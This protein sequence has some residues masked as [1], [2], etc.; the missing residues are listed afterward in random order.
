MLCGR[1]IHPVIAQNAGQPV[2]RY[3]AAHVV[4]MVDNDIGGEPAQ[5]ERQ[6][7]MRAAMQRRLC[8]V[9]QAP[10]ARAAHLFRGIGTPGFAANP[11]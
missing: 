10:W 4:H 5:H 1:V 11:T 2:V 6:V 8:M 7:I 3:A 9:V